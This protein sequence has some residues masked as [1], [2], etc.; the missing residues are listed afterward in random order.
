MDSPLNVCGIHATI[1]VC[2]IGNNEIDHAIERTICIV[3]LH[4]HEN[5]ISIL[6]YVVVNGQLN[7]DNIARCYIISHDVYKPIICLSA[8]VNFKPVIIYFDQ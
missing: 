7:H 1:K 2:M 5:G 3:P 6:Y 4:D 8:I